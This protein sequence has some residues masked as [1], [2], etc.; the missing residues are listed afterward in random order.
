MRRAWGKLGGKGSSP[1]E[2][3]KCQIGFHPRSDRGQA[4][5]LA[6]RF[7]A[8]IKCYPQC[9]AQAGAEVDVIHISCTYCSMTFPKDSLFHLARP[10]DYHTHF[11]PGGRTYTHSSSSCQSAISLHAPDPLTTS[12]LLTKTPKFKDT[13]SNLPGSPHSF[14]DPRFSSHSSCIPVYFC[15]SL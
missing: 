11:P 8:R 2:Y 14:L 6:I 1:R 15:V 3:I 13:S 10:C 5:V 4:K 7:N 12:L 9:Q